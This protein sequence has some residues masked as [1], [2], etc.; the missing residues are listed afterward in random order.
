MEGRNII[1]KVKGVNRTEK[2]NKDG[3]YEEAFKVTIEF[4]DTDYKAKL[5][6]QTEDKDTAKS[7]ILGQEFQLRLAP[8]NTKL[9]EF[10]VLEQER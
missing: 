2:I 8:A 7:F 10:S 6:I 9:D 4:V 1:G 5:V 3:L